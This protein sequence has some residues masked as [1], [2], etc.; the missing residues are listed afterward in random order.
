M[1]DGVGDK[2]KA[3]DQPVP[4]EEAKAPAPASAPKP[5]EDKAPA[6]A[7]K[8]PEDRAPAPSGAQSNPEITAAVAELRATLQQSMQTDDKGEVTISKGKARDFVDKGAEMAQK[9][10][11]PPIS[12][13][14]KDAMAEMVQKHPKE[15]MAIM[16]TA[17]EL[18]KNPNNPEAQQKM[19]AQVKEL[20]EKDPKA[21]G[22]IALQTAKDMPG[23]DPRLK[24]AA[25]IASIIP[26]GEYITGKI[27]EKAMN[28][29]LGAQGNAQTKGH[30][31]SL[32]NNGASSCPKEPNDSMKKPSPTP[33]QGGPAQAK[34]AAIGG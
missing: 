16:E 15:M 21:A 20:A 27:I 29:S 5:P 2:G 4:S 22:K 33:Q 34:G 31:K 9:A 6:S 26:G 13:G 1:Q 19:Q 23:A 12:S 3:L 18:G 11:A 24:A 28:A 17:Q 10:G 14:T 7:S 30:G 25:T 32:G 8:S